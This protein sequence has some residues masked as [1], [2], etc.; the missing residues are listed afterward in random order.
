M[1]PNKT[2][3]GQAAEQLARRYLES[4]GMKYLQ[5]NLRYPV[6]EIDLLMEDTEYVVFVEVRYR[7]QTRFGSGAETVNYTKRQKL[8][9]AALYYLQQHPQMAR[10]PMRFDV[11][12]IAGELNQDSAKIDWLKNAFTIQ[13]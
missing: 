9:K 1:V 11:I 12:S 13:E 4:Q 5:Q 8:I 10:L 2:Q 7:R 3:V 6:G